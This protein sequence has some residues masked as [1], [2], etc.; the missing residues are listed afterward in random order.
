MLVGIVLLDKVIEGSGYEIGLE[1]VVVRMRKLQSR[2]Q[3]SCFLVQPHFFL[4][5]KVIYFIDL[6]LDLW[7]YNNFFLFKQ[8][9]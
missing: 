5:D 8:N 4:V 6:Y 1:C 9:T 7:S 3:S 2:A